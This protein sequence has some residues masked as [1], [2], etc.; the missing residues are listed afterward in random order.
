MVALLALI[1][2]P[3]RPKTAWT[4]DTE[5]VLPRRQRRSRVREQDEQSLVEWTETILSRSFHIAD[6]LMQ[7]LLPFFSEA[8]PPLCLPHTTGP[9]S[10]V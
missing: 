7:G 5:V 8:C 4:F 1:E 9:C 3:L 10:V 6:D 2:T